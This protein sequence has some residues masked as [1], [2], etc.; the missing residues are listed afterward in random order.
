M[1]DKYIDDLKKGDNEALEDIYNETRKLIYSICLSYMHDKMLAEDMMQETYVNVF[2]Y[3]KKY[4]SK[5]NPLVWIIKICRNRCLN[6]LKKKKRI[7]YV[8]DN[9]D[10]EEL[11]IDSSLPKTET[12]LLDISLKILS[13]KELE[14]LLPHIIDNMKL[15][16][17]ASKLNI[18]DGTVRY[19]YSEA[20]NK[21]RKYLER[22]EH[23]ENN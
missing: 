18:P 23:N 4:K 14:V 7:S 15:V 19:R 16:E 21:I 13:D 12:P 22:I 1:L 5:T 11:L 10:Y 20:L 17:I 2:Q 9:Q 6:E 3:A 8:G